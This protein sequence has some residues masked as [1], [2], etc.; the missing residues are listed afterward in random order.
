MRIS[1]S[2]TNGRE[3]TMLVFVGCCVSSQWRCT[4]LP[5]FSC[6]RRSITARLPR[7]QQRR[8]CV[9]SVRCSSTWKGLLQPRGRNATVVGKCSRARWCCMVHTHTHTH[10]RS[11]SLFLSLSLS[12]SLTR[13]HAHT[14]SLSHTQHTNTHTHT[15]EELLTCARCG[16]AHYCDADCQ[17]SSW[18]GHG[19]T[20]C[21][22]GEC[23]AAQEI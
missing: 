18:K 4:V 6:C 9:R 20:G 7:P 3:N 2:Y 14:L 13:T 5:S 15:G 10:S 16:I 8:R 11:L 19:Q 23:C 22:T 12:L 1:T 21:D 17:M